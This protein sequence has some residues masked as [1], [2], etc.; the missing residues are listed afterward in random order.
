M[1]FPY[2]RGSALLS[3]VALAAVPLLAAC[4]A[5][6]PAAA[7]NA[8]QGGAP[9][10][11]AAP[12]P[13][14]KQALRFLTINMPRSLDPIHIDAQRI[15]NNGL[16]EPLIMQN[17][18]ATLRPWLAASWRNVEP[19][20]WEFTLRPNVTFWSGAVM[21]AKAVKASLERHQ[22]DNSRARSVLAGWEFTAKDAVTLS[23]KTPKPDP[24]L[25]FRIAAYPI[26]NAEAAAQLGDKYNQTPDLTGW[27]KPVQFVAGELLVAEANKDYWGDKPKLQRI[28]GRLGTDPQ[29]R[30]LALRAGDA[31]AEYNV[32][33]DQRMEYEREGKTKFA[34]YAPAPTTRNLWLNFKKFPALQDLKVR[35]ALNLSV[36]RD[37]LI[38]GLNH[39]LANPATGHFPI[40]LPYSLEAGTKL[41][42]A[43]AEQL[44]DEAGWRKGADGLRAKDGRKLEFKILT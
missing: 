18:D 40:G 27:F 30:Q 33:T 43:K 13:A 41:D 9:Q 3:L 7:P 26:H 34:V 8:S 23:V 6:A 5:P 29:T 20:L 38:K 11:S 21:D 22:K 10:G 36:D 15:I 12:Q 19:T 42:R 37:E 25:P 44:L 28:E 14:D 17:D 4:N 1:Q 31:D 24:G 2:L 35:Q 32:E 16:A 39:G